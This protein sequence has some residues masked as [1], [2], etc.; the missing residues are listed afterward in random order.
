M[1]DIDGNFRRIT[2]RK[3]LYPNQIRMA[4]IY[5]MVSG[6]FTGKTKKFMENNK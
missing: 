3:S 5:F 2:E 6:T 1:A 4:N